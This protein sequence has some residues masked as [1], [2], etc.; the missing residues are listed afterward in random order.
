MGMWLSMPETEYAER[1]LLPRSLFVLKELMNINFYPGDKVK[2]NLE[3]SE[4]HD[5]EG[6][7]VTATGAQV[8][9]RIDDTE[10][11]YWDDEVV[12]LERKASE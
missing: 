11:W 6:I 1:D 12:L 7:V 3:S 8:K 10:Y 2:L 9:V 4:F 5:R